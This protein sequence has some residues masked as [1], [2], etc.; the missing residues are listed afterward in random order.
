MNNSI[1]APCGLF[2][3]GADDRLQDLPSSNA[4]RYLVPDPNPEMLK[5]ILRFHGCP[6]FYID[7]I[8]NGYAPREF[9]LGMT[10][11]WKIRDAFYKLAAHSV[12]CFMGNAPSRLTIE[13]IG[14]M[15]VETIKPQDLFLHEL[16]R[17]MNSVV[18]FR[19]VCSTGT[20]FWPSSS[21]PCCSMQQELMTAIRLY[22][23]Y[24]IWCM[25]PVLLPVDFSSGLSCFSNTEL[26]IIQSLIADKGTALPSP[27][28]PMSPML[29]IPAKPPKPSV[30]PSSVPQE[31]SATAPILDAELKRLQD[32]LQ[33][34]PKSAAELALAL[35]VKRGVLRKHFL[36]PAEKK[37][38]IERTAPGSSSKQRYRLVPAACQVSPVVVTGATAP[39]MVDLKNTGKQVEQPE[40]IVSGIITV[41]R[42]RRSAPTIRLA[43]YRRRVDVEKALIKAFRVERFLRSAFVS[44]SGTWKELGIASKLEKVDLYS[45]ND[46]L[47]NPQFWGVNGGL[48]LAHMQCDSSGNYRSDF[49]GE[50]TLLSIFAQTIGLDL[51]AFSETERAEMAKMEGFLSSA[52]IYLTNYYAQHFGIS[53]DIDKPYHEDKRAMQTEAVDLFDLYHPGMA[54]IVFHGKD[55]APQLQVARLDVTGQTLLLPVTFYASAQNPMLY[56]MMPEVPDTP[57]L[58]NSDLIAANPSAE[59]ILT[60]EIGIPL[61]NDSNGDYIFSTMYGG[62]EVIDKLDH[63]LLEGHLLRWLCF[64]SGDGPVKMYEKAVMAGRSIFQKHGRKTDFQVFDGVT[65]TRNVFGM[66]TGTYESTRELSFDE[67]MTE[68]AKYGVSGCG[69]NEVIDLQDLSMDDLLKLKP[70]DFMLYPLLKEGFYCLIYGG[71][72][73]AKTWFALHL[74]ICLSQGQAPFAGWEF[75]GSAP[76]NVMY[77]AGEMD[78]AEYGDRLRKLLAEQESNPRFRFLRHIEVD[79]LRK[80]NIDLASNEDQERISKLIEMRK[81]QVVVLDNLSTLA[82]NGHT[83]GQFE[84]ILGFIS[85]LQSD[86]IIVLLVHHENRKGDFKGSGKIELVSDQSL[87]LFSAGN[88]D[89]IELL[90]RAEK[91]RMTSRAEQASFHTEFDPKNPKAVWET[92]PLTPEERDRLDID[93]PL[94]EVERN[95]G[96]KRKNDQLAWKYL[97]EEDRGTAIIEGMLNGCHDDVIAADLAVRESVIADFKQEHGISPDTINLHR[98]KAK[99]IVKN[100]KKVT[101]SKLAPEIWKLLKNNKE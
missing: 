86:G 27:N 99:E 35:N 70:K 34:G 13:T 88:G 61:V 54:K 1:P 65:W 72:G 95:V 82:T 9:Q 101:P 68:A 71:S 41:S 4:E 23:L 10:R 8:V 67:L 74:A 81:S 5:T 85:K 28:P 29:P 25:N 94:G 46:C 84:K 18:W 12:H 77:I 89:K 87:H 44:G 11:F 57:I 58:Y 2:P 21:I 43:R 50:T 37:G 24:N 14:T 93:D 39:V 79:G 32:A 53:G 66:E 7:T 33:K 78:E 31:P 51:A 98:I 52:E 80:K 49:L 69:S 47:F 90:V 59:I 48:L 62:M 40:N 38:L 97:D 15:I 20:F 83:E 22:V 30:L 42:A 6:E 75:R 45:V 55:R 76:L 96:K 26:A 91:I 92:R 19:H 73:V 36:L 56:S 16:V 100:E 17:A 3:Q 63:D 60:D 64:D